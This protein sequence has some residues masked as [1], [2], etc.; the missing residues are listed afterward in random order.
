MTMQ[1]QTSTEEI[2]YPDDDGLP[3]SDNTL[4]FQWI[5]TLQ[6]NLAAL[7]RDDPQV[8]VAGN[9]LWYP[10]MGRPEIRGAPDTLVAFGRPK[11][12]RG[13]YRQW[14][15]DGVAPQVVFEVLSPGNRDE[16]MDRKF[17]FYD[18]HGVE[19]YYVYDPDSTE[20][21]VWQRQQGRLQ[22]IYPVDGWVSPRLGIRFILSADELIILRPDGTRFMTFLELEQQREDAQREA[23][24]ARRKAQQ[25]KQDAEQA[26]QGAEQAKQDAEQARR[27]VE[28]AKLDAEQSKQDAEQARRK[29]EQANLDAEQAKQAWSKPGNVLSAWQHS[30][31]RWGLSRRPD[32]T[33]SAYVITA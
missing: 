27:K 31:E 25:F 12:Y 10:V 24:Q 16:E 11:G 3:M 22:P 4:Q 23:E 19:E 13:S 28:Q 9:L 33:C 17:A 30:C 20:L 26:K 15:E 2:D 18:A 21:F 1:T 5:V 6:G 32:P 29:A 7:Y 8:F 14:Q